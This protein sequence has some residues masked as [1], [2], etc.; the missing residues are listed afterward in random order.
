MR[1]SSP[2]STCR[3]LCC[4]CASQVNVLIQ[5]SSVACEACSWLDCLNVP[6]EISLECRAMPRSLHNNPLAVEAWPSPS[7]RTKGSHLPEELHYPHGSWL[8]RSLTW[9]TCIQNRLVCHWFPLCPDTS[10]QWPTSGRKHSLLF[11]PV[12]PVESIQEEMAKNGQH[13]SDRLCAVGTTSEV[14][15]SKKEAV[16]HTASTA[17]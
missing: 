8:S 7:P 17:Q 11:A 4:Q 14:F 12:Q 16:L 3:E 6:C 5:I 10:F 2:V 15:F 9:L 13:G 1:P